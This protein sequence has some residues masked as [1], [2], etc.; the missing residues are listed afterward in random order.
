MTMP[1]LIHPFTDQFN[2]YA[3]FLNSGPST[4]AWPSA[5]RAIY[6]PFVVSEPCTAVKMW[7][8]NGTSVSGN[9][10]A[11]II[12]QPDLALLVQTASTAQSGTSAIQEA[13]ITD[14]L[15]SA[16]I[17][18]AGLAL[19][20]GTGHILRSLISTTPAYRA[21]GVAQETLGS[22]TFPSTITPAALTSGQVPMVGISLRTLVA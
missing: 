7:W 2:G 10:R 8:L 16:G 4:G 5:N 22:L 3:L 21:A 18:Y 13:D 17:Y 9:V 12:R 20:N 1:T 6:I 15:L 19:D 14:T 11:A